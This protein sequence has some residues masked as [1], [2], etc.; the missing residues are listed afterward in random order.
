[1]VEF[2]YSPNVDLFATKTVSLG[3]LS[4]L[5]C[6]LES[7]V[8]SYA[9]YEACE[10][11]YAGTI[12]YDED[13]TFLGIQQVDENNGS[14]KQWDVFMLNTK[15]QE[16]IVYNHHGKMLRKIAL[17]LSLR[18][19]TSSVHLFSSNFELPGD[20]Q[21]TTVFLINDVDD[22]LMLTQDG[23]ISQTIS[24]SQKLLQL[25]YDSG[26]H[27][28]FVFHMYSVY[29]ARSSFIIY[30]NFDQSLFISQLK[31]ASNGYHGASQRHVQFHK[32][33]L[34]ILYPGD[35]YQNIHFIEIFQP[36]LISRADVDNRNYES[37]ISCS[38]GLFQI[39][40]SDL[41]YVD[42]QNTFVISKDDII[43]VHDANRGI[44]VKYSLTGDKLGSFRLKHPSCE[45]GEYAMGPCGEI[46]VSCHMTHIF[47]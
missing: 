32:G 14:Q 35:N 11:H 15:Q 45:A 29:F 10:G 24:K 7:L 28:G 38:V 13:Y 1:M 23:I 26:Y 4:N 47:R 6:C 40:E 17:P 12:F 3:S 33:C 25:T 9:S 8:H 34:Y 16:I 31:Y 18:L 5:P 20:S 42:L 30:N 36:N 2:A 46:L 37:K 22:I 27:T 19:R 41:K 44:I 43:H 21:P 39:P